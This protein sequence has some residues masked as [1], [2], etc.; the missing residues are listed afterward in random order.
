VTFATI[1][2]CRRRHA[3][4]IYLKSGIVIFQNCGSSF[5]ASSAS[6]GE[7]V[8]PTVVYGQ[9]VIRPLDTEIAKVELTVME[10]TTP[11]LRQLL[12]LEFASALTRDLTRGGLY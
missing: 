3:I 4:E 6:E 11:K 12:G 10:R 7:G 8:S 5:W 9:K 2:V 1:R